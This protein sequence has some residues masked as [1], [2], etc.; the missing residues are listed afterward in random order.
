MH[1]FDYP[2]KFSS[3]LVCPFD[4]D[5]LFEL[6]NSSK[7]NKSITTPPE[8]WCWTEKNNETGNLSK[9]NMFF[10][11]FLFHILTNENTRKRTGEVKIFLFPQFN[12]GKDFCF[13]TGCRPILY[14]IWYFVKKKIKFLE[15]EFMSRTY[16]NINPNRKH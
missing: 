12:T 8:I 1:L 2:R 15:E 11:Y 10:I 5:V 6:I 3:W 7:L 13:P 9:T 14:T 4:P 16:V